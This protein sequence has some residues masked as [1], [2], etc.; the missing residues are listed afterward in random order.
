MLMSCIEVVREKL[1]IQEL[2][3]QADAALFAQ[4]FKG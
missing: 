3:N 4:R 2:Q 1:S